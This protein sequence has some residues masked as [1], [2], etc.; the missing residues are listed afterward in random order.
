[1]VLFLT[2][3]WPETPLLDSAKRKNFV[4]PGDRGGSLGKSIERSA[5]RGRVRGVKSEPHPLDGAV[6]LSL[7]G[8]ALG[9]VL[10]AVKIAAGVWGNTFALIADGLESGMD[11]VYGVAAWLGY[12]VARRP[13]DA[14]HR[15]GH[16][17]AEAL[18]ALI[19]SFVLL[20]GAAVIATQSVIEIRHPHRVP[21]AWTLGV[22]V[23]VVVVKEIFFR[24]VRRAAAKSGSVAV[25]ADAW[26]HRSDAITSAAAF[27][28]I[29]IALIG[30]EGWESA[31]DWAAL[32][33]CGVIVWT[34]VALLRK[35]LGEIMD[36]A[37]PASL[38]QRAREVMSA[39]P[40]VSAIEKCR[41]RRSGS[42]LFV[43]V[44]VEVNAELTVRDG[45]SIA[46]R[47]K[48]ALASGEFGV[49]DVQVHIE[50]FG[51]RTKESER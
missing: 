47:V 22:L 2:G 21:A 33:A 40:G 13:A 35:S 26:H 6:R 38:E 36:E 51:E 25:E 46:H 20:G 16:G 43:D 31:D 11:V 15:F 7:W 29:A 4:C 3:E 5:D 17:K 12:R 10:A 30:G 50:P 44:H 39:V 41:L 1:M 24:V 49:V 42:T 19:A 9:A 14:N 8:A 27:I 37:P 45:H 34:A 18:M 32:L 28:G 23:L 48:R